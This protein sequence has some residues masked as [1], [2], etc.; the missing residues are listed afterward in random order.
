M[1]FDVLRGI[2]DGGDL[3]SRIVGDFDTEFLFE[4]HHQFDDVEA[5]GTEIVDEAGFL[6][7]LVGLDAE[8]LD[9]R[10][11][12]PELVGSVSRPP[13][14]RESPG[15]LRAWVRRRYEYARRAAGA[16]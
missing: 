15:R 6:G 11:A 9:D 14:R 2:A 10:E 1:L 4:R 8:V 3:L 13:G 12:R 7:D 16:G 5:V